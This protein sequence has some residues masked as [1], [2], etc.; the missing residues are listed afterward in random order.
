MAKF[1]GNLHLVMLVGLLAAVA[2]MVGFA[3]SA[4]INGNTIGRW[5]HLFFGL[6][7]ECCEY[8]DDCSNLVTIE[9]NGDNLPTSVN[10]DTFVYDADGNEVAEDDE[11]LALLR[12]M[13]FPFRGEEKPVQIGM[14]AA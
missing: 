2:T 3:D 11:A 13:G 12:E 1:F 7:P 8:R 6:P 14:P 9:W 10:G 5:L 4:L